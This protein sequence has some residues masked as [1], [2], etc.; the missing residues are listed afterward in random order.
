MQT[1]YNRSLRK[2]YAG[3][4][5]D[6]IPGYVEALVAKEGIGLGLG[7]AKYAGVDNAC[8]LPKV[9]SV[10]VSV[11]A[12][13]VADDVL[14]VTVNGNEVSE[15]YA[16]SHDDT[17]GALATAL[18]A[19]ADVAS[20]VF[21]D[22]KAIALTAVEGVDLEVSAQVTNGG[23]GMA[24]AGV[25]HGTSDTLH[26]ISLHTHQL[27]QDR[28]TGTVSYPEKAMVNA[29]R[30]GRVWVVVEESV[31]SDDPVYLRFR[32]DGATKQPGQ[33]RKSSDS[34]NAVLLSGARFVTSA[35]AGELAVVEINLP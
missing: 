35:G 12:D 5:A 19:L 22:D 8:R 2:A 20:A 16:T 30:R 26:A 6:G 32:A 13:L 34:G 18:A 31:T 7:L 14:T 10:A 33:F 24:T 4:S 21:D 11:S 1:S 3:M 27:A 17:M 25:T 28:E 9:N 29:M 15:T 23:S